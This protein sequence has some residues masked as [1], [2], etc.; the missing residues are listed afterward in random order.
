MIA[1]MIITRFFGASEGS[2]HN[3]REE[4]VGTRAQVTALITGATPG[5][6]TYVVGG[7]RQSLRAVTDDE[8]PIPVGATVRI[9][10]IES[11]TARVIR[12]DQ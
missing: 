11:H 6:V 5:M 8:E 9:R 4:L 10:R 12:I 1:Y 3:K 7:S 2:S